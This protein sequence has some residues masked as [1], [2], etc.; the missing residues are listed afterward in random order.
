MRVAV[1][2]EFYPRRHD[3][4]LGVWAH[5]QALAAR[6]A[7]AEIEVFVLHRLV[8][9]RRR[10]G[11]LP[12]LLRAALAR[13]PRRA[14]VSLRPLRLATARAQL[15]ALGRAGRRPRL[16][17]ALRARGP[18]RPRPR[19]LRGPGGRRGAARRGRARRWSSRSTA[20]TCCGRASRVPCGRA[21]GGARARRGARSCSPTAPGSSAGARARRA[22]DAGRAPR[23][24]PARA[25][26]RGRAA[27]DRDRRPPRRRAS[28]TPTCCA[29]WRSCPGV[30]YLVIGDGPE[31]GPLERLAREL[32]DRRPRRVHGPARAARRRWTRCAGPG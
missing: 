2:A 20:A 30:R 15:R 18:L 24:R 7:G 31:R 11:A 27:A 29:R 22:R 12:A 6:D 3:P 14:C 13:R 26:G 17:R 21:R 23:R 19:P 9:P 1:V 28:A 8:P 16:R 10:P 32:G 4:V 5:R 25:A